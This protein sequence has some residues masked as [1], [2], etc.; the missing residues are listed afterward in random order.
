VPPC[1]GHSDATC[2]NIVQHVSPCM[3]RYCQQS[4]CHI[5]VYMYL[6]FSSKWLL[7]LPVLLLLFRWGIQSH[8]L[9]PWALALPLAL[10]HSAMAR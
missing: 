10:A 7:L 4:L 8:S 1:D 2:G 3:I 5:L 9:L 6:P